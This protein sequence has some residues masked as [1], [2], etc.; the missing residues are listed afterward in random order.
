[1]SNPAGPIPQHWYGNF[2]ASMKRPLVAMIFDA[3]FQ[4]D[5]ISRRK[6]SSE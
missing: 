6:S 1:M 5:I 3:R 4:E 2:P